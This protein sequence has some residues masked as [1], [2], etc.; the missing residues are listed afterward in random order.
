MPRGIFATLNGLRGF[1]VNKRQGA[2]PSELRLQEMGSFFPRVA[3]A[4]PW[5]GIGERF[6]RYSF[7]DEASQEWVSIRLFV[8]SFLP[9]HIESSLPRP[10]PFHTF[11]C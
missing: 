8:Q 1:A 4:Q 7:S 9:N 3:K 11:L 2:T 6:Q 10:K 5:A